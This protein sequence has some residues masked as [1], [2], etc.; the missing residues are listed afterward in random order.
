MMLADEREF[1]RLVY[2]AESKPARGYGRTEHM[3]RA[4]F[5]EASEKGVR[6]MI[7]AAAQHQ[8][9]HLQD[10]WY[11]LERTH[12]SVVARPPVWTTNMRRHADLRGMRNVTIYH[13]HYATEDRVTFWSRH[14]YELQRRCRQLELE[15]EC[16]RTAIRQMELQ[17]TRLREERDEATA[18]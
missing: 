6:V 4:A 13:D 7:V 17:L 5:R 12:P 16:H 1:D 11:E 9:K 3:L 8:L 18:E 10:R 14:Y 15:N 2:N